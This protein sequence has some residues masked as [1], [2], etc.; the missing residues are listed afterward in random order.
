MYGGGCIGY[1]VFFLMFESSEF[2]RVVF[3]STVKF[4]ALRCMVLSF[5]DKG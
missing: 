5:S 3:R 1:K 4:V 2:A